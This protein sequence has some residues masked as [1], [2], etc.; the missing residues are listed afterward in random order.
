MQAILTRFVVNLCNKPKMKIKIIIIIVLLIVVGVS[1]YYLLKDKKPS[2]STVVLSKE[3]TTKTTGSQAAGSGSGVVVVPTV[4]TLQVGKPA[5]ANKMGVKVFDSSSI[6]KKT[7]NTGGWAGN[8]T[9]ID[10][11]VVWLSFTDLSKG[12]AMKTDLKP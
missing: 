6:Y 9:K 7:V 11:T 4:P 10:P 2:D 12:W 1:L 5:Y 3:T 8:V